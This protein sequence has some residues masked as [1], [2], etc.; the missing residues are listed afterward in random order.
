MNL[1]SVSIPF[2]KIMGH[3]TEGKRFL[4]SWQRRI[5]TIAL[6]NIMDEIA[7]AENFRFIIYSAK[8]HIKKQNIIRNLGTAKKHDEVELDKR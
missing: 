3:P 4:N 6:L 5:I 1:D 7:V 2:N 8:R